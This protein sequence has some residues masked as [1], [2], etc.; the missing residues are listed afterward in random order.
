MTSVPSLNFQLNILKQINMG[1]EEKT[2]MNHKY[3]LLSIL[4]NEKKNC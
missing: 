1:V 2:E 4:E 3:Q